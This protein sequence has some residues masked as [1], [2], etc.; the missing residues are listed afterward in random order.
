MNTNAPSTQTG[1]PTA[2]P[3]LDGQPVAGRPGRQWRYVELLVEWGFGPQAQACDGNIA[4]TSDLGVLGVARPLPGDQATTMVGEYAWRSP[5][6]T[7]RRGVV[8]PVLYSDALRGGDRTI[9]TVRSGGDGFSFLPTDLARGPLLLPEQGFFVCALSAVRSATP[10]SRGEDPAPEVLLSERMEAREGDAVVLGWGSNDGPCVYANAGAEPIALLAGRI[11]LPA[12]SMAAHPDQG[13]DIVLA[14]RSP[15]AGM[16][17]VTA[18]VNH[19]A[20]SYSAGVEWSI[21]YDSKL[22]RDLHCTGRIEPGGSQA[23]PPDTDVHR[24]NKL[25]VEPGE[26]V[27]LVLRSRSNHPCHVTSIGLTVIELGGAGRTWDLVRDVAGDLPSG[28]PHRD[29]LGNPEVWHFSTLARPTPHAVWNPPS[30]PILSEATSASAYQAELAGQKFKTIRATV[31]GRREQ[32]WQGAMEALFGQLQWPPFPEVNVRPMV[33]VE[34]P[35]RHL[36]GLWEIGTWQILKLIARDKDCRYRIADPPFDPLGCETD[37][38]ILALDQLGMHRVARDGMSL[39]LEN[40]QADGAPLLTWG[41]EK[42]HQI[43]G[44]NILWVM[45]EHYRLTGD[46]DWLRQELPRLVRAAQWIL[47]RRRT[48]MKETLSQAE[49]DGIKA[50]TWSPYGLQPK[51]TCGDGDPTGS[52]YYYLNDAFA[53]Q[54]VKL[55]ADIAG[56]VDA[57][58]AAELS[59]ECAAWRQDI[60]R[61]LDESIR[62][63]PVMKVRDGTCRRFI[64][65]GFQ[66]RGPLALA[67]PEGADIYSH[68]GPYSGDFT[69]TS[70][71]IEAWIRSGLLSVEDP[72]VNG[73]FDIIEDLFLWDHPWFRKRRP[74]YNPEHD[75]FDFGWGYQSGWERLPEYY[76]VKDDVPNFLRS[77]LNRCAV[78]LNLGNWTFNEHTTFAPNDKSH[79]NAVFLS[80]FRNMLA[81]EL[82]DTLWLARATPRAWLEQGQRIILRNAPTY[83]GRLTYQIVSDVDHGEINATVVMPA[84]HTR[85][86]GKAWRSDDDW[87][88]VPGG[89][90][91]RLPG[92][93]ILRLR[94]PTGAPMKGVTVNG[95]PWTDFNKDKETI[96]LKGLTGTVA[97]T[98]QY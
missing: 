23:I 35:C 40:Q 54:S 63:S 29:S 51:I 58:T 66:D 71:A 18:R 37:R 86:A 14:W 28:N 93:V 60:V 48:T 56:D 32:N 85:P 53:Y 90:P 20:F 78:D 87:Y 34:V 45:S 47:G 5:V 57:A 11:Q 13:H 38:I 52:R 98:A 88:G 16:V 79:G 41:A 46:K 39:W 72:R 31:R 9:I 97:V 61:V 95:K 36:T 42:F 4:V 65:Q 10:P 80:N 73:H 74:D 6:A 8:I 64:P 75:W 3:A 91:R 82:G 68:C 7:G 50:G 22:G 89:P 26:C 17:R 76:L 27:S 19:A 15:I 62:L 94:H 55:L 67:M 59:A 92:S 2:V 44:L 43:G 69:G 21:V 96:T 33:S 77:W 30:L 70:A 24:L 84:R 83:F 1:D 25:S 12:R 81:M 49:K